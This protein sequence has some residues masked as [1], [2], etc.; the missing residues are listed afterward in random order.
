M[1]GTGGVQLGFHNNDTNHG[2][3]HRDRGGWTRL[4]SLTIL[5]LPAALFAEPSSMPPGLREF[6]DRNCVTC[7]STAKA[8]AGLDLTSLPYDLGDINTFSRWVRIHDQ[9]RDGAMPPRGALVL[10]PPDQSVFLRMV[11]EPMKAVEQHRAELVGRSVM[12][13][14]N[15]YEYEN[16][17]RDLLAAPWLQLKDML[18]EDGMSQGFNK[19]GQALDISHVQMARY[20]ETAEQALRLAL[21]AAEEPEKKNRYY[22]RDQ[23]RFIGRMRYTSFN[24]HPERAT[25]P[26]LGFEA[27]PDVLAEKVPI[28]AGAN[29]PKTRQ[30][31]GFATPA[32]TYVG[33]E[34]HFD[35]FTAPAGGR[36]H[37]TFNA[38]SI[39]IH[40]IY[41][42]GLRADK[43][44]WWR[45][46]R[47]RT[48]RGRTTEPVTIYA[49][50]RGEKRLL[51][52][53][54]AKP[55]PELHELDVYLLPGEQV[56][57]DASGLFRSRP[58]FTGSPDATAEGMPG[59]AYRWMEA[60]GPIVDTAAQERV[61]QFFGDDAGKSLRQFF[62]RAYRRPATDAEYGRYLQMIKNV[63]VQNRIEALITG[64]TAVLC[65]PGFLYLEEEPGPLTGSAL[66]NR[67]S[68]FLWNGP[69]D[70]TLR[71]LAA[72]NKLRQPDVL[73][74]QVDRLLDH[75][76]S[77]NFVNAFL[78]YWLDLRKLSETTPDQTLYPEYYLDDLLLESALQETQLFVGQLIRNNL[79]ARYLVASDFTML[80]SHLARHYGLPP[81]EGVAMRQVSLPHDSVRGGLLTQAS[82]LKITANG[83]TTSP[84][85]RG[86]WIMERIL[87][88]PPPPPP[89]G[90]PAIEP[91]TR[92]AT[93][94]RQQLDKHRSIAT[95]AACHSKIDPAGFALENFDVLGGWRGQY[96]STD[97]GEPVK[98]IGKNGFAFTFRM[99]QPVDASG[100]LANG[101]EFRNV[102]DLKGLLLK[103]ERKIARNFVGQMI[104][105]ATGTPVRFADREEV[106]RM[107]D[108]TAA[109]GYKMRSLVHQIVQ[110]R[111]FRNK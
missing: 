93:T 46:D 73:R 16:T 21:A 107:L 7:H 82:V 60:T 30:L 72:K 19:S 66:A 26:I 42:A 27:Q 33:N 54:D 96:R 17:L 23:K 10:K 41:G 101:D 81:V 18:P 61:R 35:E 29:D 87:G 94:I 13:R 52:S 108:A 104:T 63:P 62:A 98:G 36:Y 70:G 1:S 4:G 49:L 88:E 37:L 74:V 44:E 106:E 95:C 84:V 3:V 55:E 92:G 31:E 65:S 58:G 68:Y 77:S 47:E 20:M 11:G 67:L 105:Y 109:E 28:S 48:S 85:L 9:V 15:R 51:G 24:R 78:D 50:R 57:P 71:S 64:Y 56:L 2:S 80:N 8:P 59:V 40:T 34:L 76:N 12:R 86:A 103:D 111:I 39:W 38:F 45:P 53:F 90:V 102:V 5:F 22:A 110:S 75:P 100:R 99:S 97:Q 83:T 14:L 32:S 89:A 25:I 91:D 69:P 43:I 79:A 6:L